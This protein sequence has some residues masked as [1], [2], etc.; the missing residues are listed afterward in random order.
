MLIKWEGLRIVHIHPTDEGVMVGLEM[1]PFVGRGQDGK[2]YQLKDVSNEGGVKADYFHHNDFEE[3]CGKKF[4]ENV[5][6]PALPHYIPVVLSKLFVEML[7][8]LQIDEESLAGWR[9]LPKSDCF[10]AYIRTD[11][12]FDWMKKT[13]VAA[14][15][16]IKNR[17]AQY[18][19][20]PRNIKGLDEFFFKINQCLRQAWYLEDPKSAGSKLC[21]SLIMLAGRLYMELL[22]KRYKNGPRAAVTYEVFPDKP[23]VARA[24]AELEAEIKNMSASLP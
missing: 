16:V 4:K 9:P 7:R 21:F 11:I 23:S 19:A 14:C 3:Y 15:A 12:S 2:L 18:Y 24:V 10:Y 6:F 13:S 22:E 1:R 20:N 17:L 5:D 8:E